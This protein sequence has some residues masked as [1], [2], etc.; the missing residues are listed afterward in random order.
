MD[1]AIEVLKSQISNSKEQIKSLTSGTSLHFNT[2][3]AL[4]DLTTSIQTADIQTRITELENEA[5]QS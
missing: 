3:I 1:N 2:D 5:R 4:N